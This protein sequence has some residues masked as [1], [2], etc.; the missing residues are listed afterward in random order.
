MGSRIS[1][2]DERATLKLDAD[3]Y[4]ELKEYCHDEGLVIGAFA[5]KQ[6]KKILNNL[7]QIKRIN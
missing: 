5:G 6:L 1:K 4:N 7:K 3:I 2:K